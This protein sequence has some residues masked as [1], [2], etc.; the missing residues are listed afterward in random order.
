M[1]RAAAM[2]VASVVLLLPMSGICEA[3]PT[4]SSLI[5]AAKRGDTDS[6]C[7]VARILWDGTSSLGHDRRVAVAWWEKAAQKGNPKAMVILGDLYYNGVYVSQSK[8][9]ARE[10]YEDAARKGHDRAEKRLAR[11]GS[12]DKEDTAKS[13]EAEVEHQPMVEEDD[14]EDLASVNVPLEPS[15]PGSDAV[16]T[17]FS[18]GVIRAAQA[19]G[20]NDIAVVSFQSNGGAKTPLS[21]DVQSAVL[22]KLLELGSGI[23]IVLSDRANERYIEVENS[24]GG[25]SGNISSSKAVLVGE[26]FFSPGDAEGICTVRLFRVSDCR[27]LYAACA[28]VRWSDMEASQMSG[29]STFL[30]SHSFA[31][32]DDES[33]R[34]LKAQASRIRNGFA[35]VQ[36]GSQS[37]SN[38]LNHRIAC[39]QVLS[40][41][42]DKGAQVYERE[43]FILAAK[44]QAREGSS[45]FDNNCKADAIALVKLFASVGGKIPFTLQIQSTSSH[46][47]L[48]QARLSMLAGGAAGNATGNGGENDMNDR[49]SRMR[50]NMRADNPVVEME[51]LVPQDR[52]Q[53]YFEECVRKFNGD[54]QKI[55]RHL[56]CMAIFGK[57]DVLSYHSE[58]SPWFLCAQQLNEQYEV[59]GCS[60]EVVEMRDSSWTDVC[61]E[62]E[63]LEGVHVQSYRGANRVKH[64]IRIEWKDGLPYKVRIKLDASLDKAKIL[65]KK[66]KSQE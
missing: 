29:S 24:L 50:D 46:Q 17:T 52:M 34:K 55:K 54:P 15:V 38:T 39:A 66:A 51:F 20:A 56:M 43:F 63:L 45:L 40:T 27:I 25:E 30:H 14:D 48:M 64:T 18:Q 1:L 3:A 33:I 60:E 22:E 2:L 19:A 5:R 28:R 47:L 44:E 23:G 37:S 53:S 57:Q 49:I 35:F 42:V 13:H 41:L 4:L 7:K 65:K 59:A 31:W 21:D 16:L 62:K 8:T 6:M 11:F 32:V 10:Y 26:V 58:E 9:K 61:T 36:D 12:A